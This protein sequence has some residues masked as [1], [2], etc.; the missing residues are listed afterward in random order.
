MYPQQHLIWGIIF[1]LLIFF[2][3]P[4]T[5]L[6]RFLIILS[7]SVLIDID[8][9]LYHVYKKK[10]FSLK[11]T[12]DWFIK[13][14]E[15]FLRL[16]RKQRNESYTGFYFLH[17]IEVLIFLF[18]LGKFLSAYFYFILIGFAFHL[19]LDI[20][21]QIRYHDRMDKFSV[22]HDFLKFRKLKYIDGN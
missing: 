2:L 14:K 4:Q 13:K 5:D 15:K 8:H 3:F 7:S 21:N 10:D 6:I 12:Y 11:Q 17:G 20:L 9:Y 1:A 22:I 18:I 19:L 16:S